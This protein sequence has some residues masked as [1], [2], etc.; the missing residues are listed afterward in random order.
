MGSLEEAKKEALKQNKWLM[1]NIMD[2]GD[3]CSHCLNRDIWKDKQLITIIRESFIFYQWVTKTYI[4]KDLIE[5]Y[6]PTRIPCIFVIEPH[7]NLQI[8]EFIVPDIPQQVVQLKPKILEFLYDHPRLLIYGYIRKHLFSEFMPME[9]IETIFKWCF[10]ESLQLKEDTKELQQNKMLYQMSNT[11][12]FDLVETAIILSSDKV[13]INQPKTMRYF[14][15]NMGPKYF[16]TLTSNTFCNQ[17]ESI[18]MSRDSATILFAKIRE[19]M[20]F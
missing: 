8:H 12:F 11:E 16:T 20:E 7:T 3:F 18:N 14:K 4:A 17:M 15:A 5:I 9:I 13:V 19:L 10:P 1:I 2:E 6:R